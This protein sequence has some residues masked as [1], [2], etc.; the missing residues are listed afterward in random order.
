MSS[1]LALAAVPAVMRDLLNH[2]LIDH[3]IT[4]ALGTRLANPPPALD[5]HYLLS[6]YGAAELHSEIVLGYAMHLLHETPVLD[7]QAIRTA[8]GGGTVDS[9]IL[10][11]A[12]QALSAAV[13][14]DQVEQI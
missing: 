1:P 6:A 9:T 4:G 11:P 12:F 10:P 14:A 8:L 5:L 2:G 7:R 13:L 3:A